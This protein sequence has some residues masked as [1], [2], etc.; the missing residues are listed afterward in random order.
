MQM[1]MKRP[2]GRLVG[3]LTLGLIAGLLGLSMLSSGSSGGPSSSSSSALSALEQEA[4]PSAS[5]TTKPDPVETEVLGKTTVKQ[6]S[7]TDPN[8]LY[9]SPVGSDAND[10]QAPETAFGSLQKGLDSVSAGQTLFVM[11]GEYSYA[12]PYG[13]NHFRLAKSGRADAWIR[14]LAYPGDRPVIKAT[15]GSGIELVGSYLEFSGFEIAGEGFNVENNFGFG[16]MA[17]RGH[18]IRLNDNVIHGMALAGIG[19]IEASQIEIRGNTIYNNAYWGPEQGSGISLWKNVNHGFGPDTDGYTDRIENN[20]IF[21]NENKVAANHAGN[22]QV[23]DGNGII[24]DQFQLTGYT[25]R[26]LIANNIVAYNGGRGIHV[27]QSAGVDIVHNTTY[28]NGYTQAL[29]PRGSELS[30][31]QSGDVRFINNLVWAA[32]GKMAL[33]TDRA[34]DVVTAG[35]LYAVGDFEGAVGP[36]ADDIIMAEAPGLTNPNSDLR[37]ADVTPLPG[38]LAIDSGVGVIG[39]VQFDYSGGARVAG[40]APD[41]GA[42]ETGNGSSATPPPVRSN[43]AALESETPAALT[44]ESAAAASGS[45]PAGSAAAEATTASAGPEAAASGSNNAADV[46]TGS[47]QAVTVAKGSSESASRDESPAQGIGRNNSWAERVQALDFADDLVSVPASELGYSAEA[48]RGLSGQADAI[49]PR[50]EVPS[51]GSL[52]SIGSVQSGGLERSGLALMVA[53]AVLALGLLARVM[54]RGPL[55]APV[56]IRLENGSDQI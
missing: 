16:V 7:D 23:T 22:G 36:G 29:V 41:R 56:V 37:F 39:G 14:I 10:G 47:H 48:S 44:S 24:I 49:N 46:V 18:H 6:L 11:D 25:G 20:L 55:P 13:R 32:E 54:L 21:G 43:S 31:S 38:S 51:Q 40:S 45:V 3:G 34:W 33:Y 52:A 26:V 8:T 2:S 27:F 50:L 30:A 9:V 19:V 1:R 53:L 4:T 28:L 15:T 42:V 17:E 5:E 12:S 35:N